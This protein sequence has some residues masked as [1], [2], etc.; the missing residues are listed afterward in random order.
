LHTGLIFIAVT[1]NGER[2]MFCH[3]GANIAF[4][5]ADLHQD[6]LDDISLVALSGYAFLEAPQ[7]D[8]AWKL[9]EMAAERQIPICMDTGLDPV[10]LD[11]EAIK[12][13]LP[14]LSLL[15]SGEA[16]AEGLTHVGNRQGQCDAL[17][18]YGIEQVAVKLGRNGAW[19]GW[20]RGLHASPAFKVQVVD[21]TSAGDA[22][23]AGLVYGYLYGFS[24]R[25]S[26]LLANALGGLATTV[27]GA[28][29][30]GRGDILSFLE[31]QN[32]AIDAQYD[33]EAF[34]EVIQG[35]RRS[36]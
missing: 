27:Y 29:R 25:G 2:T 26:L 31:A 35:L 7:R 17:L 19:L 20:E 12:A 3:R 21:T 30:I 13:V 4:N 34:T 11:P 36:L 14:Y 5:P 32:Q 8:T 18:A 33:H 9:V 22:F 23:T 28:A 10:I 16:E 6:V 15:I 1:P 24:P